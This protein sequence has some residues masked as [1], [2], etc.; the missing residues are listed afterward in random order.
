MQELDQTPKGDS[1]TESSYLK[2][3][4]ESCQLAK[5]P[6]PRNHHSKAVAKLYGLHSPAY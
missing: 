6:T 2:A 5:P 1:K 3:A 4:F